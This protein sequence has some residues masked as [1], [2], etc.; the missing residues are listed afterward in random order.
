MTN[1]KFTFLVLGGT[2]R[3][4]KHFVSIALNAGH[5]VIALVRN[6]EKMDIQN[7]NLKVIKGTINDSYSIDELLNGVDFV[8]SMLGDARLQKLENVNTEFVKKLIPAMRRQ[9]VKRFLYQAGG[10]SRPHK[11]KLPF[12]FWVLK[13]T[14]VRFSGL[15]GQHR[16]NEAVIKYLTEQANDIEWMVHR[17]SIISDDASKGNL[18]RSKTKN[19]LAT[20]VDCAAFNYQL[21]L[22][23]TAIHT[24]DLSYYA[25]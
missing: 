10:F 8:V 11:E 9:K 17:A 24:C 20:F 1:S 7:P 12:M 19:S 18:T 13:Q 16:D 22:D 15:L 3:T 23:E 4:G 21:L 6:P 14:M 5:K 2:G 25:K